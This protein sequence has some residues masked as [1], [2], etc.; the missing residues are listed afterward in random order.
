MPM[1]GSSLRLYGLSAGSA[2]LFY[3]IVNT[4]IYFFLVRPVPPASIEAQPI[5][6][7]T[8]ALPDRAAD[9]DEDPVT[10]GE[11]LLRQA[12][13]WQPA[14]GEW[15][16]DD[17]S[18]TVN[19]VDLY[20]LT[21]LLRTPLAQPHLRA[22]LRH[23]EGVG[24]GLIFNAASMNSWR[25]AHMVRFFDDR[26]LVWGYYD[27]EGVFQGQ[28]YAEVQS[29]GNEEQILEVIAGPDS[30][31]VRHN[32]NLVAQNIPVV[33]RGNY[34]GLTASQ[35]RVAFTDVSQFSRLSSPAPEGLVMGAGEWVQEGGLVVQ[36]SPVA[37]DL[38][39]GI[40]FQ[41]T[42]YTVTVDIQWPLNREVPQTGGGLIF[43][44][45]APAE[46]A[47]A[48]M[49]RFSRNGNEIFWGAFD[50][51]RNFQG[52]GGATLTLNFDRPHTLKLVVGT[53]KFSVF[54]DDDLV[55]DNRPLRRQGGYVGLLTYGGPVTFSNLQVTEASAE[56]E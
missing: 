38:F 15:S 27:A 5:A 16:N 43:N 39:A 3:M 6:M 25:D 12:D 31:T 32:G 26:S 19:A 34:V 46:I 4:F 48:Q 13:Q 20:D 35:S 28:G 29:V 49:V 40:G 51:S 21:N 17:G 2:L 11:N 47:G 41:A 45:S 37:S 8:M 44:M 18:T 33:S 1:H 22:H 56:P 36:R 7:A 53:E 23:L 50:A 54:V 10:A 52:D 9:V 42:S 55:A 30:Y 14:A 24:G